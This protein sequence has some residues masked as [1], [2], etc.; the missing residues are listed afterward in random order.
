M[1]SFFIFFKEP[2]EVFVENTD[3]QAPLL[4][5][6]ILKIW[7]GSEDPYFLISIPAHSY[8][9]TCLG[10]TGLLHYQL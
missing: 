10:S 2:V 1:L 9:P 3:S 5:I 8:D 4:E 7:E 6:L